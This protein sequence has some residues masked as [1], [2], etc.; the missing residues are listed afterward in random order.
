MRM[1]VVIVGVT[2]TEGIPSLKTRTVTKLYF[3]S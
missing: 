3:I 1:R 2:V